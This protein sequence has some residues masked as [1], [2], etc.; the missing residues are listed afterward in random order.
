MAGMRR[1]CRF[2][3]SGWRASDGPYGPSLYA[4]SRLFAICFA[5]FVAERNSGVDLVEVSLESLLG[6]FGQ[7][8]EFD[9][10]AHA[11]IAS[12]HYGGG[13]EPL[14]FDP[15]IHS[16]GGADGQRHDRLNITA[17]PAD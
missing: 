16:N 2:Y 9:A 17:V 8:R 7:A 6:F 12:P 14:L 3:T 15:Q 5:F 13:R 10:H 4:R 1:G 11:G